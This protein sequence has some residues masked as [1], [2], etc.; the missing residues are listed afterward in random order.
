VPRDDALTLTEI[1]QARNGDMPEVVSTLVD[2]ER[3]CRN[4]GAP[5]KA[6]QKGACSKA[7]ACDLAASARARQLKSGATAVAKSR[8]AEKRQPAPAVPAAP[9]LATFFGGLPAS[10]TAVEVS[11]WRCTRT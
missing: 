5:L 8:V 11:G 7:C 4:C 6:S 2:T 9:D 10:V 1:R 3:L